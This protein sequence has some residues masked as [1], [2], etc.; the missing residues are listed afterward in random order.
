MELRDATRKLMTETEQATGCQVVVTVDSTLTTMSGVLMAT[1]DRPGHIIR[2]HPKAP[3]GVDYYVAYYCGMIQRFFENPPE[4]RFLFGVGDKGR[5]QFRKLLERMPIIKRL[6]EAAIL[7]MSK[8]LLNGLMTHLRSIPLGLR[9]DNWLFKE[10]SEFV[11]MQRI[12]GELGDADTA[13]QQVVAIDEFN[14]LAKRAKEQLSSLAHVGFLM[15]GGTKGRPD[16]V[17]YCLS[18][19][20]HFADLPDAEVQRITF[21]VGMLGTKGFEIND[22]AQK[23]QLQSMPGKFSGMQL[24]CIMYVGFKRIAPECAASFDLSN[25]YAVALEM[26]KKGRA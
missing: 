15:R 6:G 22:P 5:Y 26:F 19:L 17:M 24:L 14:D 21:E 18:A 23:Y 16:A 4:E 13:Y 8:Q 11:E 9:L 1:S 12:A 3:A 7:A 10:H 20:K 25:E 2:I